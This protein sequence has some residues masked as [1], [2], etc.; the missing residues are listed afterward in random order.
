MMTAFAEMAP[1]E[2]ILLLALCL[3]LVVGGY[4]FTRGAE[5]NTQVLILDDQLASMDK[6]LSKERKNTKS[7]ALP[8]LDGKSIRAK[9][10]KKLERLIEEE[11]AL[12]SG[13]GHV[14]VDLR[15][16][17]QVAKLVGEVNRNAKDNNLQLLSKV[18]S[19]ANLMQF[20][21]KKARKTAASSLNR[22]LYELHLQ[23]GYSALYG[24]IQKLST[25]EFSV[26][27]IKI[28]VSRTERTAI[29]G[30]RVLDIQ[31]TLAL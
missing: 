31:I 15:D 24:F 20:V 27:P 8:E 28:Q 30:G 25:L 26:V 14:F 1:R 16:K 9:D 22:P 18:Q 17:T 4:L 3:V 2:K 23:G 10:V 11:Q 19:E 29:G 13:F 12:L 7:K 5:L 6:K 21:S